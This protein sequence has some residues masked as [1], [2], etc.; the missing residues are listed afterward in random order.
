MTLQARMLLIASVAVVAAGCRSPYYADR[1][2]LVGG[3]TGAGVGALIGEHNGNAGAGALIGTA[4]GTLAGAAIGDTID[5]EVARNQA[6]VEQRMGRR[7]AAAVSLNDVVAMSQAGLSDDVISTH[8]RAYGVAQPPQ[9]QDLI[10]LKNQGVSDAVI[11]TLQQTPP[12]QVITG[13]PPGRPVIIEEHYYGPPYPP[14]YYYHS[15]HH[16]PRYCR[17]P[18][19]S[20]GF[21]YHR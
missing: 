18:G 16:H 10:W 6:L 21:S 3:L 7:M 1:G 14:P 4:V 5:A 19:V 12:P 17:P 11:K 15:H 20:W 2:A 13:P 8:I 9:S